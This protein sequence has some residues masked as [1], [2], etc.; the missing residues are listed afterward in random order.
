MCIL[1]GGVVCSRRGSWYIHSHILLDSLTNFCFASLVYSYLLV[2][3]INS[4]LCL[5][6]LCGY[7]FNT[8]VK[9]FGTLVIYIYVCV[10]VCVCV[11]TFSLSLL[12][13]VPMFCSFVLV[14]KCYAFSLSTSLLCPLLD[15]ISLIQLLWVFVSVECWTC[16][17][18]F[19]LSLLACMSR[20]SFLV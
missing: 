11:F 15:F 1:K 14:V 20:C 3:F 10:C 6:C 17:W 16:K 18:Y 9:A 7:G 12:W 2:V 13:F 4:W 8:L 5:Q 19:A